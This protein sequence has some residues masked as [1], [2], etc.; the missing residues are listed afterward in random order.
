MLIEKYDVVYKIKSHGS[1]PVNDN[2]KDDSIVEE[3]LPVKPKEPSRRTARAKKDDPKEPPK[4]WI[5]AEEIALCQA[6]CDVSENNVAGNSMKTKGFW[7]AVIT[8][9]EKETGSSRGYDLILSKWENKVRPRIDAFCA[10]INNVEENH[11]I[12]ISE[13]ME[14]RL[15]DKGGGGNMEVVFEVCFH[16]SDFR[17]CNH[18]ELRGGWWRMFSGVGVVCGDG[19]DSE[20]GGVVCGVVCGVVVISRAVTMKKGLTGMIISYSETIGIKINGAFIIGGEFTYRNKVFNYIGC[21]KNIYKMKRAIWIR[22]LYM[23]RVGDRRV[24]FKW[25]VAAPRWSGEKTDCTFV[26]RFDGERLGGGEYVA[27]I[28]SL[29]IA[30]QMGVRNVYVSVDSKLVANQ[31]LGTYVAKE[32]NMIK[33]LEKAKSLINGF[34]NFSISQVPRSKNKKADA[35]RKIASTSFAHL[36]KQVLVEV[37]KDKSIQERE[38]ETVV[39]EEGPTWMTQYEL[40]EGILYRR[41]F[42]KPWLSLVPRHPQQPLTPITA[43]W[44]F[45][46]WGIDVASPFPKGPGKVKFL[47][48][49]MDYFTKD[50]AQLGER[51][52]NWLEELPHVLWAHR[53]MIKSR[54]DDTLFSLTYG[55]EA[56]IPAEIRMPTYRTIVVDAA[57][58]DEELRLNLDLLEERRERAAIREAKAK[59]KMTKYYNARVKGVT[60]RLGDFVYHS[61]DASHA[62]DGGKLGPKWEGPYEVTEAL[63]DGAYKLRSTD[64]TVLSR[65]WDIANLKKCYL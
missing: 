62:V 23:A 6:W 48:A 28:A 3:V 11:E 10:I 49:A 22:D 37:L 45:Y 4:D 16:S 61:Y 15:G 29:Q 50:K 26:F 21:D 38:I 7:D 36:S 47:I 9:F 24:T 53:T 18:R 65:T 60:F 43:P 35:L 33:Y 31:V 13:G 14:M 27:L 44:P 30:V 5:V 42:L 51:N 19:V 57:H 32:E 40:L 54:N 46:K 8:Y 1:V 34:A 25:Q 12:R 39:E 64:G 55:T 52:K 2:E 58:N 17:M 56:F 41:S 20:V 59:L 63:G